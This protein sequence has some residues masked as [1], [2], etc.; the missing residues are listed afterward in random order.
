MRTSICLNGEWDFMPLYENHSG[1]DL[2]TE[3]DYDDRKIQVPSS[4]R[5]SYV[6]AS[7]KSFGEIPEHGYSPYDLHGYPK[8]WTQAD[9]GVLHR[10]FRLPDTMTGGTKRIF[11]RFDGIMQKAA[12]Y[13]D[14]KLIAIWEDGYLPLLADVTENVQAGTTHQLHVVCGNFDKV[15]LPSGQ[16]KLTGLV[17]SWF[18][19][20]ARG[21]WQ[22]VYV[23][24]GARAS[25]RR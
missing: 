13:L 21:I 18:G 8:E 9:A 16:T 17:G 10:E 7:G 12:V 23:S 1:F 2:P 6:R 5:A 15:T 19:A 3:L 22:D 20:M 4:W 11:L 24:A 25:G 14:R